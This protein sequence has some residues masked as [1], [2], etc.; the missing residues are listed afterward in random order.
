[1]SATFQEWAQPECLRFPCAALPSQDACNA[2]AVLLFHSP[3]LSLEPGGGGPSG[4]LQDGDGA[5]FR[6]IAGAFGRRE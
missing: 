3:A 1:M 5:A 6:A 2:E 4:A